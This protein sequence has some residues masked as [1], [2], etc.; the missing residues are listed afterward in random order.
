V[1]ERGV[2]ECAIVGSRGRTGRGARLLT[3]GDVEDEEGEG[4]AVLRRPGAPEV[5]HRR[6]R[7]R[8][9][10]EGG[11]GVLVRVWDGVNGQVA[12]APW[13]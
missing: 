8:S 11:G 2:W 10:T 4:V 6:R 9:G 3:E 7:W 1:S 13:P 12:S 5:R